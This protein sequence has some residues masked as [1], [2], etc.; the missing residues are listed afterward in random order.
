[1][2]AVRSACRTTGF[3]DLAGLRPD[4]S[5]NAVWALAGSCGSQMLFD[6]GA[7]SVSNARSISGGFG[8]MQRHSIWLFRGFS[9]S[10]AVVREVF[11]RHRC[12]VRMVNEV[13]RAMPGEAE[14]GT[15]LKEPPCGA[16]H[17]DQSQIDCLH[18]PPQR[19]KAPQATVPR[20]HSVT[21]DL[22]RP[23]SNLPRNSLVCDAP[24]VLRVCR[25]R[26]L[27][28]LSALAR[29]PTSDIAVMPPKP[30]SWTVATKLVEELQRFGARIRIQPIHPI[31]HDP[32]T[33]IDRAL[34]SCVPSTDR[35]GAPR[36]L[37]ASPNPGKLALRILL[38]R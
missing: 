23:R 22:R 10:R 33:L 7:G 6:R 34:L 18:D 12:D 15:T 31:G 19:L 37:S 5:R 28:S 16:P 8:V 17:W 35:F 24:K 29:I 21:C 25:R 9:G 13:H 36:F 38:H 3:Y 27:S 1:M 4:R 11:F 30:A 20:N 2:P 26:T 14:A 32:A